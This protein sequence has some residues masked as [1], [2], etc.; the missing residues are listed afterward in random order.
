MLS[1]VTGIATFPC[2][3]TPMAAMRLT[4]ARA[5]APDGFATGP[6]AVPRSAA[7][8]RRGARATA[9]PREMGAVGWGAVGWDA[10]GWGAVVG[11]DVAGGVVVTGTLDVDGATVPKVGG[12]VTGVVTADVTVPAALAGVWVSAALRGTADPVAEDTTNHE[13][14]TTI[15]AAAA[16]VACRCRPVPRSPP[17]THTSPGILGGRRQEHEARVF[18]LTWT[19]RRVVARGSMPRRF[20]DNLARW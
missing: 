10:V 2:D 20:P 9:G 8:D 3:V 4:A 15:A 12:A 1:V 13:P 18:P 5:V 7:R 19:G 11:A 17:M 6:D 14:N 16:M